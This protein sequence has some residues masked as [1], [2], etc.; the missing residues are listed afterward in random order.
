MRKVGVDLLYDLVVVVAQT[1]ELPVEI[2]EPR[3]EML[4]GKVGFGH[5]EL[6]SE[7]A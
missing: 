6:S 1:C 5:A 2:V 7:Y 4:L 3:D